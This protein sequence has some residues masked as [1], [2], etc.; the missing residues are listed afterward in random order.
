MRK[1]TFV[2]KSIDGMFAAGYWDD[3][4]LQC[5]STTWLPR[6]MALCAPC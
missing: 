6:Y 3:W 5:T 2:S 4:Y 1:N